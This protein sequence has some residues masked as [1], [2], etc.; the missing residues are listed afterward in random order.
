LENY[1]IQESSISVKKGG[2]SSNLYM[3][4]ETAPK[5]S[6]KKFDN[7]FKIRKKQAILFIV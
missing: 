1:G 4:N 6:T 7:K 2:I 3:R 5:A